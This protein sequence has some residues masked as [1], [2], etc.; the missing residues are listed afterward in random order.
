MWLMP[1]NLDIGSGFFRSVF[2]KGGEYETLMGDD[3]HLVIK[4]Q[5]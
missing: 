5:R 4:S 2:R 1:N 3:G